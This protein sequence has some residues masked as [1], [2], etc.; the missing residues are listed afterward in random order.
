MY[1]MSAA[2]DNM[3]VMIGGENINPIQRE[4]ANKSEGSANSHSTDPNCHPQGIFSQKNE[5]RG[6]GHQSTIP[7]QDRFLESME[8]LTKKLF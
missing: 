1:K 4:L 7:R 6:F 2:F 5:F 8:T 3:D